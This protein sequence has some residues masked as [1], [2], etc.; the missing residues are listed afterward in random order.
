[1]EL[2]PLVECCSPLVRE[3]LPVERAMSLA[4]VFKALS[5][6]VRLRLFSLI[7]SHGGG[8]ACGGVCDA[9][10]RVHAATDRVRDLRV[11][12]GRL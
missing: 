12:L 3:P 8:E 6:P 10:C 1:M 4:R 7:A 5:D 11:A 9:V 2:L